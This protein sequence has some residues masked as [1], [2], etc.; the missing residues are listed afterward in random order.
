MSVQT[1]RPALWRELSIPLFT[2]LI[3]IV[4]PEIP[5]MSSAVGFSWPLRI[6]IALGLLTAIAAGRF[7]GVWL[8]P[9]GLCAA[10]LIRVVLLLATHKTG[11][12]LWVMTVVAVWEN[13]RDP[14]VG[15]LEA[16]LSF[17]EPAAALVGFTVSEDLVIVVPP[18]MTLIGPVMHFLLSGQA[19]RIRLAEEEANRLQVAALRAEAD[20]Q[21]AQVLSEIHERLGGHLRDIAASARETDETLATGGQPGLASLSSRVREATFELRG[22]IWALDPAEESWESIEARL[23]RFVGDETGITFAASVPADRRLTPTDRVALVR[24]LRDALA[25]PDTRSIRIRAQGPRLVV[26]ADGVSP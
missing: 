22:A 16:L 9:L 19:K 15:R 12:L 2:T 23:R 18:L 26:E 3:L 10:A 25:A 17:A 4:V 6:P 20:H 7:G 21:R 24:S 1:A 8:R 11:S 13:A 14:R 5:G